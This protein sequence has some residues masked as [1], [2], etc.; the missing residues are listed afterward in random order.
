MA[1]QSVLTVYLHAL[2]LIFLLLLTRAF[3]HNPIDGES[4]ED[5]ISCTAASTVAS[6]HGASLLQS[7]SVKRKVSEPWTQELPGL[8]LDEKEV[9]DPSAHAVP[10]LQMDAQEAPIELWSESGHATSGELSNSTVNATVSATSRLTQAVQ[11]LRSRLKAFS[12]SFAREMEWFV[13]DV[14]EN[15]VSR[16]SS[17][18]LIL[19]VLIAL[20][21]MAFYFC[22]I[23][24]SASSRPDM[25]SP[26]LFHGTSLRSPH[27][28]PDTP[29][30]SPDGVA[31]DLCEC[32]LAVPVCAPSGSFSIC[33]TSGRAI[34]NAFAQTSGRTD[35]RYENPRPL[36]RLALKTAKGD[37][38]AQCIEM[39]PS[40]AS[41]YGVSVT[42]LEFHILDAKGEYFASLVQLH[43]P[44]GQQ[45][46]QI[47]T[48]AGDKLY[49]WGN[50]QT[51]AVN[52]TD[53]QG[54]L[55]AATDPYEVGS[56]RVHSY[57]RLRVPQVANAGLPLCALL[58]IG[59]VLKPNPT[60]A[61]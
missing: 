11:R 55:L 19:L 54:S 53:E 39:M 49:I 4:M 45:R 7:L 18:M 16:R 58:C 20:L 3:S 15:G 26:H 52:I 44:H 37:S 24:S 30:R 1:E 42:G 40:T 43:L 36:W 14:S 32:V 61:K 10:G 25:S 17:G 46:F 21:L 13:E 28:T 38:F 33:D 22:L 2:I 23:R 31:A 5:S 34:L 48:Q 12:M 41:L 59:Q 29:S 47:T 51:Q 60:T 27:G 8:Q 35:L 6:P 9:R 50:F 57:Y 56:D